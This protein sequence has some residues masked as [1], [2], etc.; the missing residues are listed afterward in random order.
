[1][2]KLYHETVQERMILFLQS[3]VG[4]KHGWKKKA[5]EFL[6]FEN[7]QNLSSYLSGLRLPGNTLQ[8]R[9]YNRGCSIDWLMFG[10]N[11]TTIFGDK[12]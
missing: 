11:I 4:K 8:A 2:A 10:K 5:S 1:M 9:L 6:D 12:K 3:H 7:A